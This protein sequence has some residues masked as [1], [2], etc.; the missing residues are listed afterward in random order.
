MIEIAVVP[1]IDIIYSEFRSRV[2]K[3][4]IF[5]IPEMIREFYLMNHLVNRDILIQPVHHLIVNGING[6]NR[7]LKQLFNLCPLIDGP[8]PMGD[9]QLRFFGPYRLQR[10]GPGQSKSGRFKRIAYVRETGNNQIA[11]KGGFD[12]RYKD[13]DGIIG[14][15]SGMVE[16]KG[17][18]PPKKR[19]GYR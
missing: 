10:P 3:L 8:S 2:D 1:A 13:P 9:Q 12:L 16:F 6:F 18:I 17:F 19:S 15:G 5:V 14:F 4:K 7:D 11:Y